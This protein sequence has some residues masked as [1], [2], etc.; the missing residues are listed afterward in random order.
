MRQLL[1]V[2]LLAGPGFAQGAPQ[3]PVPSPHRVVTATRSVVQFEGLENQLMDAV[4]KKDKDSLLKLTADDFEMRTSATNVGPNPREN[5][6]NSAVATDGYNLSDFRFDDVAV[7]M[8]ADSVAVV[9]ATY[10]QKATFNGKDRSGF[11][12][13]VDV[14]TKTVNDWKLS[15]RYAGPA[16]GKPVPGRGPKVLPDRKPTG[17]E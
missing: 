16:E 11:L 7:H 2:L 4:S 6:I 14:W 15:V 12:F 3:G 8:Y 9:S 13:L 17:R 1:C 10:W 5:W